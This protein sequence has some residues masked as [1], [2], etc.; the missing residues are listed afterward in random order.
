ML[1]WVDTGKIND[2]TDMPNKQAWYKGVRLIVYRR[3]YDWA[4]T[5][6]IEVTNG[7]CIE[8]ASRNSPLY[9][10]EEAMMASTLAADDLLVRLGSRVVIKPRP[11]KKPPIP[12]SVLEDLGIS[13]K[14][15]GYED[16]PD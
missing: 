8:E 4:F 13:R 16:H 5:T 1:E 2:Y 12:D 9:S 6:I 15:M 14:D 7:N 3:K 10:E 11:P